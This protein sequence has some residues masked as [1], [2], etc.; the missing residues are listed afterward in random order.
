M[1]FAVLDIEKEIG[2]QGFEAA[3]M[4]VVYASN[5]LHATKNIRETLTHARDLLKPGGTLILNEMTAARDYATLTFGLLDGWFRFE[6]AELRIPD[7]PLLSVAGWEKVMREL[8]LEWIAAHGE[9][10]QSDPAQF[11]QAVM[12]SRKSAPDG[13]L[14]SIEAKVVQAV[15]EVFEM[16]PESVRAAAGA[17]AMLSFTELGA[18]SILS[19]ELVDKIN[20]SLGLELKTTAIFN[21]PGIKELARHIHDEHGAAVSPPKGNGHSANAGLEEVLKRL[22]TGEWTYEQA[23]E[24]FGGDLIQ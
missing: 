22:E 18:D 2:P 15:A 13:L 1:K 5:V 4:D 16:T 24:N 3:S 12:A 10:G 17:S 9:P 7:S 14:A 21:Y 23:L 6:D 8:G 19:A 20:A 11:Q